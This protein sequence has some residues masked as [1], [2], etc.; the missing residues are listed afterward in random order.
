MDR[1]KRVLFVGEASFLSTG[2]ST[3]YRELLPRL[4]ET[5][6]YEIAELGSYAAQNHPLVEEFIQGRWKFYGVMPTT[7]EESAIFNQPS[8]HPKGS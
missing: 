6:K 7:Q 5:G 1:K 3:Y 4:V 2:F 8:K